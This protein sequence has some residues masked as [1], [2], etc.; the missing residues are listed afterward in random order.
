MA[1]ALQ[2]TDGTN[3]QYLVQVG[4]AVRGAN[5]FRYY[6]TDT[7]AT[8]ATSGYITKATNADHEI[9]YDML[10]VGDIVEVYQLASITAGQNLESDMEAGITDISQHAVLT[11]S[12]TVI[13]LSE[14]LLAATLTYTA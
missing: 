14:D 9:A 6:T 2:G 10:S 11:K 5:K 4:S 7:P 1:F 12:A 3:K 13:D 8:V